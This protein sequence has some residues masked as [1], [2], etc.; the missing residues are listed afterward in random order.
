MIG[1]AL[2]SP[3]N[4]TNILFLWATLISSQRQDTTLGF[5]LDDNNESVQLN[6]FTKL[7]GKILR[8]MQSGK[9]RTVRYF[10]LE[11]S[12]SLVQS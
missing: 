9:A 6:H 2:M 3:R 7:E 11:Y 12:R 8:D 10:I 1:V 4:L 5:I